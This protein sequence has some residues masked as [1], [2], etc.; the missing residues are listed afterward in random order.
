MKCLCLN[1]RRAARSITAVYEEHLRV[2]NVTSAQFGLLSLLAERAGLSQTEIA[3]AAGLDQTTLS[4][5]LQIVIANKWVKRTPST[6]DRRQSLYAITSAGV[7]LRM[8]AMPHWNRA[9][10]HMR[11]ALGADWE[12][13]FAVL[14]RLSDGAEAQHRRVD[15]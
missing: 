4:R 9:Q 2:C 11:E 5:N 13:A 15:K 1:T 6:R 14:Q 10:Q 8:E 7:K 12:T 3:E